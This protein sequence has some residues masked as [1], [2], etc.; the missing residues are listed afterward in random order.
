M[1]LEVGNMKD[2]MRALL[3]PE[4]WIVKLIEVDV[5]KPKPNE[6]LA[7]MISVGICGSD[8]GIFEGDHWIIAHEPGGHG[9]E[10]GAIAVEVGEDVEGISEGDWVII[11]SPRGHVRQRAKLFAG[12][13]PRVVSA[14]HGWWFPENT[15]P[16][17]GWEE[18]NIN[19]LTDNKPPHSREM[20]STNLRGMLC[21][22]YS[23]D[24]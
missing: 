23:A 15:D 6:V 16:G 2:K 9:H 11:E 14:Q 12:I 24:T 20:G 19:I 10:T 18:S 1:E 5:P 4:P 22:V 3:F 13:D 21:K 7:K 8:V 17:H